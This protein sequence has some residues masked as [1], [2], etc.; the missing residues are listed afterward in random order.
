MNKFLSLCLPALL[1]APVPHAGIP[2]RRDMLPSE[3]LMPKALVPN[4][5]RFSPCVSRRL[6]SELPLEES[7][8]ARTRTGKDMSVQFPFRCYSEV[9]LRYGRG[10]KRILFKMPF[11][12]AG[13]LG[14]LAGA[15]SL[16]PKGFGFNPWSGCIREATN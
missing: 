13:W 11:S 8:G 2:L 4:L 7:K 16:A 14:Q 3:D 9:N 12:C 6:W 10:G 15:M 1:R 5:G